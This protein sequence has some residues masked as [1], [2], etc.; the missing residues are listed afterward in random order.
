MNPRFDESMAKILSS[1]FS[2]DD[3]KPFF[4]E[5]TSDDWVTPER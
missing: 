3:P 5:A 4:G 2:A 1:I